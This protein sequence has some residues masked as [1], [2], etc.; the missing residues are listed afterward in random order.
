VGSITGSGAAGRNRR[1]FDDIASD[2][3]T[4]E[5]AVITA[6]R[7]VEECAKALCTQAAR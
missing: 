6:K 2:L 1:R 3:C 4:A 7:R 5:I